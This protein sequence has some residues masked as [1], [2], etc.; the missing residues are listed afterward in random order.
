MATQDTFDPARRAWLG[1]H[2]LAALATPLVALVPTAVAVARADKAGAGAA[3]EQTL[4]G[5]VRLDLNENSYGPSPK[6][7]P[8]VQNALAQ[9]PRY[10][11]AEQGQ[12]LT[13]QIAA[14]EGVPADHV[15][16]GEVLEPL[17]QHLALASGGGNFV[18]SVPGYGA[19]VDAA[20]PFGG[21]AIEVP[22]DADLNNDLPALLAAITP[23][24]RAVFVVNPHN[25]SGTIS[26]VAPFDA[27]VEQASKRT[28]VIVDEA[29]L[30]YQPDAAAR[31]AV[32]QLRNGHNVA[33]FRTFG[34]IHGLAGLQIG[35]A[36]APPALASAL[37]ARGVGGAHGLNQ[38]SIAAAS[39]TLAD[40]AHVARVREQVAAER[41]KWLQV[42]KARG[43]RFAQPAGNFVFI[44]TGRPH[45]EVAAGL[46]QRGVQIA[47]VFPP[48]AHWVRISIGTPAENTRARTALLEVLKDA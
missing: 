10:V 14:L 48:Y 16:I 28:L 15:V 41:A 2:A 37:H 45:A 12:A 32:R 3:Q 40:P 18:Y 9:A 4:A 26:P 24:T 21:R 11:S 22:L 47:R 39:A 42:L 25:P 19:L 23:D 29:Y 8:A 7:A 17:G 30:D 13:A 5:P 1:R 34:K 20:R 35:Y 46:L 38:L 43:L 44:D 36:L 33:V 6:V 27:F 31:T